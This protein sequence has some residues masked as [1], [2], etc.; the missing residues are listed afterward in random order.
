M[1]FSACG[2]EEKLKMNNDTK[3]EKQSKGLVGEWRYMYFFGI[4]K[5]KVNEIDLSEGMVKSLLSMVGVKF[6]I[7]TGAAIDPRYIINKKGLTVWMDMHVLLSVQQPESLELVTQKRA[8]LTIPS[9]YLNSTYINHINWPS[10]ML[11]KYDITLESYNLFV[12]PFLVS[13]TMGK[14]QNLSQSMKAPDG[15]LEIFGVY[16][17]LHENPEGMLVDISD[18]INFIKKN[19]PDVTGSVRE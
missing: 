2:Q 18:I 11:T 5:S 3:N 7:S 10:Q 15:S 16:E 13:T 14:P 6:A 4:S 19:R 12:I 8:S 1:A 9:D 17:F